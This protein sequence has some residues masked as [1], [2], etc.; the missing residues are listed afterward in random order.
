MF[1]VYFCGKMHKKFAHVKKKLYLCA[2]FCIYAEIIYCNYY[3][4]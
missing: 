4:L 1:F 3:I 2:L